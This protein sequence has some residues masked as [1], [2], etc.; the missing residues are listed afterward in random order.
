MQTTSTH[1][2]TKSDHDYRSVSAHRTSEGRICYQHCSCGLWRVVRFPLAGSPVLTAVVDEQRSA[3][4]RS[5]DSNELK[6]GS[7]YLAGARVCH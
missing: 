1:S 6:R 4:R 2:P 7:A 3:D 5:S